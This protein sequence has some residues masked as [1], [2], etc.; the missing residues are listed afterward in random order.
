MNDSDQDIVIASKVASEFLKSKSVNIKP[1]GEGSNNKNYLAS[2]GK[3]EIVIK[4]S[5]DHKEYKA[6]EDY[7]KEKWCIERS[8][9]KGI[10]GPAVLGLG[11]SDE[12]AYMIETFV[13]GTNGKKVKDK[14]PVFFQLGKYTKLIHS[15]PASGFGEN[16]INPD[17]GIF[18]GSWQDYLD[19][20]INS[21]NKDDKLIGLKVLT[22]NQAATVKKIFKDIKKKKYKFGLNH[23]DISV[24]NTLVERS[25]KVNLLDWGSAEIH[26]IPYFDFI[27]VLGCQMETGRPNHKEFGEFIRGYGIN[28][29]QFEEIKPEIYKLMLLLSF[30]KLRWAIDKNPNKIVDFTK[31]A[32]KILQLNLSMPH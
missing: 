20:N 27:H 29:V 28:N 12:R 6:L 30:D 16:L 22:E 1:I 17:K 15:I 32:K 31:K 23:G 11:T 19:F 10:P 8:Q 7:K 21:L 14:L 13:Q 24:W 3:R 26:I 25:G 9:E 2:F 5:F 4:L 18:A